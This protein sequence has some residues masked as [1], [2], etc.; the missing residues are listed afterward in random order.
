MKR[1]SSFS[2]SEEPKTGFHNVRRRQMKLLGHIL[3]RPVDHPDRLCL[4][5]PDNHLTNRKPPD[6]VRRVGRPRTVWADTILPIIQK[7]LQLN[8]DQIY[9]LAQNR[10]EWYRETERLCRLLS[11]ELQ[12]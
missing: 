12:A 11:Q 7:H 6:A 5:E 1:H 10:E 9:N 8:R 4:F 3:R 2:I